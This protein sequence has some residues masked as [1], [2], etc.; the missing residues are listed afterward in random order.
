MFP[1]CS[2]GSRLRVYHLGFAG[3]ID[4]APRVQLSKQ[5]S[6][7]QVSRRSIENAEHD[8]AVLP[9][10]PLGPAIC[11]DFTLTLTAELT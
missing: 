1:S 7:E 3:S 2:Q 6:S 11:L 4:V 10:Q 8:G 5:A 9:S